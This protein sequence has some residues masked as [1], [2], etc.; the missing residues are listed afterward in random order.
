MSRTQLKVFAP[1]MAAVLALGFSPTLRAADSQTLERVEVSGLPAS[2]RADVQKVCPNLGAEL[3]QA[4]ARSVYLVGRDAEYQ[5]RFNLNGEQVDAVQAHGGPSDYRQ[6]VRTAMHRV[7]CRDSVAQGQPQRFAFV[8]SINAGD[9]ARP[10]AAR[11]AIR[12]LPQ[13]VSASAN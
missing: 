6:A 7:E 3:A 12:E 8:L 13:G 11:Y 2:I 5:V 10:G 9:D 4:M 1:L